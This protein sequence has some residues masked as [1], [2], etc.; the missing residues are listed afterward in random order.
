[1]I[2]RLLDRY[3]PVWL[4]NLRLGAPA[5][6]GPTGETALF[7]DAGWHPQRVFVQLI[8]KIDEAGT[9][10]PSSY[11]TMAG[12]PARLGAWNRFDLKWRKALAKSGLWYFHVKEFGDHPFALRA[13]EIADDNLMFGFVVRLDR[14]DYQKYYR[15][16]GGW[17]GKAQPDSMYG[18][19]F[20]YCLSLVLEIALAEMPHDTLEVNFVVED[21]HQNSGA[22][23]EIVRQLK[24]KRIPGISEFLG[25]AVPAD[26]KKHPGLQAADGLA[27][28]AWHLEALGMP[29]LGPL[30][31]PSLSRWSRTN[32]M[33]SPIFRCHIDGGELAKFKE[34][35]FAHIAHR[36]QFGQRKPR[37]EAPTSETGER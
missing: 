36:R 11:M 19:C 32:E 10:G 21:G 17:G 2:G 25:A 27:S 24:K 23:T 28:G 14:A 1:M 29:Q 26:K 5:R 12:Y 34:G 6:V 3:Q 7:M 16:G 22:P 30:Q 33:K 31:K 13:P 35:Y 20:R 9:H 18:L 37:T 8:A 4:E 15:E